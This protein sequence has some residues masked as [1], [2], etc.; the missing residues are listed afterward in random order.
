M[1]HP[2]L[3]SPIQIGS[4]TLKNR[5]VMAATSSRLCTEDGYVTDDLVAFYEARAKGGFA[6]LFTEFCYVSAPEGAATLQISI[7]DDSYIP[8]LKRLVDAVHQYDCKF[9]VQLMH[10]GSFAPPEIAKSVGTVPFN[11]GMK[12]PSALTTQ[13]VYELIDKFIAAAGR[14]KAA[15]FDGVEIHASHGFLLNEFV[16]PRLN[17]RVDEF[18][19]SLEG[20]AKIVVD[21]IKGIKNTLGKDF[22]VFVRW[23]PDE[24]WPDGMRPRES[25]ALARLVVE[26]GADSISL[27]SGLYGTGVGHC[28]YDAGY[29]LP[30][31]IELKR[32]VSVPVILVGKMKDPD[33]CES[34]I[35][36]GE[37]DVIAMSRTALADPE[38]PNKVAEGRCDEIVPCNACLQRCMLDNF[39]HGDG[40]LHSCVVNPFCMRETRLIKTPAE[41]VK[42]ILVV[43]AGPAGLQFAMLAAERGHKVTVY[44]KNTLAGG[45]YRAAAMAPFKQDTARIIAYWVNACKRNGVEIVYNTEVT[46]EL[47]RAQKADSVVLCTGGVPNYPEILGLKEAKPIP[48]V[49]VLFGCQVTGT[50]ILILG[51]GQ[52]GV[53]TADY[54][55]QYGY[56]CTIVEKAEDIAPELYAYIR[57]S[58]KERLAKQNATILTGVE[59]N[60][61]MPDSVVFTRNGRKEVLDGFDNVVLALGAKSYN[62]LEDAARSACREVHVL[63]DAGKAGQAL[64]AIYDAT[65]LAL[66]I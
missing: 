42:N 18:G 17:R 16:S 60:A 56:R 38:F 44:E 53:E 26:A 34:I 33:F 30:G 61:V 65:V 62:P 47:I 8:G 37:A 3:N 12:P 2:Y 48:A 31:S 27:S 14:A 39:G 19:G 49:D 7:A 15:G 32:N 57:S 43:G 11:K 50:N 55:G 35:A 28:G 10:A 29:N 1:E 66:K 59:I 36:S 4:L 40:R 20:R 46:P 25:A 45:Q 21:I 24:M 41:T 5:F 23:N 58:M 22:P 13:E 51:G 6:M 63:G 9:A 64:D 54:L 52:V